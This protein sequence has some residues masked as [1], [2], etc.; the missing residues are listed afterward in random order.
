MTVHNDD[1]DSQA[2][3]DLLLALVRLQ[4]DEP[5]HPELVR[6]K[7][8][9]KLNI[10]ISTVALEADRSRTLIGHDDCA[11]PEIRKVV[12]DASKPRPVIDQETTGVSAQ[13]QIIYL[14]RENALL[15][16]EKAVLATRVVDFSNVARREHERADEQARK[17]ERLESRLKA[18]QGRVTVVGGKAAE[19][20]S[21][22]AD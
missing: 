4:R 6:R 17:A 11:Y 18:L 22:D 14:R 5:T 10:N 7:R 19:R 3:T 12:Q 15:R 8:K 21:R 1:A 13:Q 20:R 16:K 9:G 2:G